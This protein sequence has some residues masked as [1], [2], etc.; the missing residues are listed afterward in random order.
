MC[1]DEEDPRGVR[2]CRQPCVLQ[3]AIRLGDA[4]R[5]HVTP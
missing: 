4:L 5:S 3:E 1:G 2:L